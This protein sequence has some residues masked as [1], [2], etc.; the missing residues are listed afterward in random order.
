MDRWVPR[1][2]CGMVH[3]VTGAYVGA[4]LFFLSLGVIDSF[5]HAQGAEIFWTR[6]SLFD[7]F[8]IPLAGIIPH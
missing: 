1:A 8:I 3:G 5:V 6:D 2:V 7:L 4:V